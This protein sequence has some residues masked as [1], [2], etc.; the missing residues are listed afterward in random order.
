MLVS[1]RPAWQDTWVALVIVK[2]AERTAAMARMKR[3]LFGSRMVGRKRGW[4]KRGWFEKGLVQKVLVE[5]VVGRKGL[6][7]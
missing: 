2:E 7:E 5:K 6:V 3:I 1:D 4:L